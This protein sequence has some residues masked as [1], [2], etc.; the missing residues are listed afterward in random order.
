MLALSPALA[1]Q[2]ETVNQ[3]TAQATNLGIFG[4]EVRDAA[5]DHTN[6]VMYITTYSAT[7]FFR[8]TDGGTTWSGLSSDYDLG[9]PRGVELDED[10]NVFLLISDGLFKSTDQGVSFTD[11][12]TVGQYGGT[13]LINQGRII[14]GRTDGKVGVSTDGGVTFTNV[15]VEADSNIQSVAASAD[16]DDLYAVADDNTTSTLY[17]SSDAGATWSAMTLTGV[18]DRF[19]LVAVDPFESAHLFL[20]PYGE[21]NNPWQSPD[22]GTNWIIIPVI[23]Y[24]PSVTFDSAGRVYMGTH[25]SDDG[26]AVWG[27]LTTETP[28]TT[29]NGY[30]WADPQDESRLLGVTYGSL[31]ISAN[32]GDSWIDTNEGI[33]AVT[34]KDMAQ[35]TDK[36]TVWAA[37]NAGLAMTSNFT[38][39]S[40]T[41]EFPIFYDSYAESVWISPNDANVV[42]LGGM[43]AVY[44]SSDGGETWETGTGWDTEYTA[45]QIVND[46]DDTSVLYAAAGIQ[47]LSDDRTGGVFTSTDGGATWSSMN[48]TDDMP[49]Q[50]IAAAGDGTLYAGAG[51]IGIRG[52]GTDGLYK[53]DGST[54]SLLSSAPAEE[55]TS[56]FVDRDDDSTVYVTAS[57]FDSS[58]NDDGGVYKSTDGGDTWTQLTSGLDQASKYRVITQQR[59]G[60]TL[61]MA[62][63]DMLTSAG[64][65][66]KS[67]DGGTTWGVYYT[68]LQNETFQYLFFDG[69]LAGTGRGA[70]DVKG[71]AQVRVR[72]SDSTV[73]SGER[74]NVRVTLKDAAT[75]KLL[76]NRNV[77]LMKKVG[78]EWTVIDH[79]RTNIN[80]RITF[81][82]RP[83]R[84]IRL[85]VRYRPTGNAAD[86]YTTSRSTVK[87]ITLN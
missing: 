4:G 54:W 28:A 46:A 84:N 82:V 65:I 52:S 17:H 5:I 34:V 76:K 35:S 42:V 70:Y 9:E 19:S 59:S 83:E 33:T 18:E 14:V 79:G 77:Q 32:R 15:T 69:L 44:Y 51:L 37:T 10:G 63:T 20:T 75:Q 12:G 73:D 2:A 13:F 78:G 50:T 66:Y 53:Y 85:K 31:A 55:I 48:I 62:A 36:D 60:N 39:D 64:L 23:T 47:S 40:P 1:A 29:V 26:G 71:K 56:V 3:D 24:A 68:G 45:Y 80:G 16:T 81:H 25:Y 57:N 86:E 27:I 38:A 11:L 6:D 61:Y 49:T 67:T 41:W 58:A 30:V 8:S 87:R 74:V 72:L 21:D 43:G 22:S 7:G